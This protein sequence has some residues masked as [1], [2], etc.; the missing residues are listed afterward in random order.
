MQ[1]IQ[2]ALKYATE[3]PLEELLTVSAQIRE[4]SFGRDIQ[5]CM[6]ANAKCGKCSNNCRFCS[7]SIHH[8]TDIATHSLLDAKSLIAE[9]KRA[10]EYQTDHFCIVTS[11][12]T[13]SRRELEQI[14]EA[15]AEI[16]GSY[17]MKMCASLG[18]LDRESFVM[19]KEAGLTR[20]HHNLETSE[21]FYPQI[22]STQKW[23]ERYDTVCR[24]YD[25]GLEICSGALF[26]MGECWRD[27]ADLA[28]TLRELGVASV[29]INFLH[30]HLGT[31]L[32]AQTPL[33]SEE[34]L[35]IIALY[36]YL[37]PTTTIRICGGRP[38]ILAD[39]QSK[40][41]A[42][43]ANALMTGNYLTLDGFTPESDYKMMEQLGLRT[44]L[45]Q[46]A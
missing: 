45:L 10:A 26:G 5:T 1:E 9:A 34:A 43:G 12:A 2:D 18:K 25:V 33:T 30:A 39:Q 42:A 21:A 17:K 4:K 29:P 19:L 31:P 23:R 40:M 36:R 22:C 37:L 14:A 8:K 46:I 16:T 13:I 41:F 6:L 35:R 24:A 38:K 32:A 7:Q 11:G 28:V 44:H 20:Y 3:T 15:V 27:R